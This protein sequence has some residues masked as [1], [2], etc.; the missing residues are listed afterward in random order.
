MSN[1]IKLLILDVDGVLTDG[2][3]YLSADGF[4]TK[5]FHTQDGLGI[6]RC[7]RAGITVAIISGRNSPVVDQR[8]QQLSVEH[9]Y[10]GIPDKT[11]IYEKLLKLTGATPEQTACVGDD[12]PDLAIMQRSKLGIAVNNA[13]PEVLSEADWVSSRNGGE[14]AVREICDYLLSLIDD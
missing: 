13:V 14:G 8:M 4:E 3:F 7:Q 6:K 5:S 2:K 10:Q 11:V 12:I 9:V 1:A